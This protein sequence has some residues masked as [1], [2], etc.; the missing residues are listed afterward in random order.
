[1]LTQ[2]INRNK[3]LVLGFVLVAIVVVIVFLIFKPTIFKE[4]VEELGSV[5]DKPLS[6]PESFRPLNASLFNDPKFKNLKDNSLEEVD[7][8]KLDI[9][10]DNPFF[11]DSQNQ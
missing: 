7:K 3:N 11:T 1:M 9:G 5:N 8:K 2:K 6:L 4:K 10:K